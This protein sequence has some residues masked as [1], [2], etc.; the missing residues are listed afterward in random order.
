MDLH[1]FRLIIGMFDPDAL[2]TLGRISWCKI[3]I[4]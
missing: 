3:E 4:S 2:S 1:K